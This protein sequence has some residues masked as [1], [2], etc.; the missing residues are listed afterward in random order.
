HGLDHPLQTAGRHFAM[1]CVALEITQRCN[2]DCTLCYL[3]DQSE[4]VRDLPLV[5]VL[6]RIDRV[7]DDYGP[8]TNIQITGG[9]PTLRKRDELIAIVAHAARRELK[10]S[11]FTNGIKATRSLL[12]DLATAGLK[13]VAFHV[14][15][16]QERRGYANEAELNAL[17]LD[18]IARAKN[19]G[20]H[21]IFNT[22]VFDGNIGEIPALAA[23]FKAH[24]YDVRMAS[25]QLQAATGR[26]VLG[27]TEGAV[28]Q[29][30]VARLV[31]QGA[32]EDLRFDWPEV[33]HK[34]CNRYGSLLVS[35]GEAAP[36]FDAPRLF[37][38]L[39]EA[40]E[41]V[42][43]D[44]HNPLR[45]ALSVAS[46]ALRRPG[47]VARTAGFGARKAWAL[48]RGL[49]RSRGQVKKLTYYI[50]NFMDAAALERDRCEACV[51]MTMT[52]DGP[53]SMCVHNAKRDAYILQPVKDAQGVPWRPI[54][55]RAEELPVKKLKG[56]L[57]KEKTKAAS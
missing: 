40:A 26:G 8:H 36:L 28:T 10:P 53:V 35:G 51:F 14:D 16:T 29:G 21:I 4:A 52:R 57:R 45:T 41:T 48:R 34:A 25:F 1:G 24:A 50:H 11:L 54:V 55:K 6:R 39:F 37:A 7:R 46:L 2:L 18:Y 56:R 20:L 31:R 44:R 49:V 3:S 12:T 47:L 30:N 23:F 38:D 15:M 32:G 19:L 42:R 22:T 5:E 13:D 9:D 27:E 33:G 17:R 43:L